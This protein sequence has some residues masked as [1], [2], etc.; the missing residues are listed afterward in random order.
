MT[1]KATDVTFEGSE[2]IKEAAD[3]IKNCLGVIIGDEHFDLCGLLGLPVND[4]LDGEENKRIVL[5]ELFEHLHLSQT[6]GIILIMIHQARDTQDGSEEWC[7]FDNREGL[8]C[9]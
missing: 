6:F 9:V 8:G 1:V 4:S 5:G 7:C 2:L 3:N